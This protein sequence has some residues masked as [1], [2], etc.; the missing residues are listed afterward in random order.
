LDTQFFLKVFQIFS[1]LFVGFLQVV[2]R[3]AGVKNRRVVFATAVHPNVCKAAFGHF[4]G[5]VHGDLSGLHHFA[6]SRF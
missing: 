2:Y 3:S 1:E 6:L 4:L 5:K